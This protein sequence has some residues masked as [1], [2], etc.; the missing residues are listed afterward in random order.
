MAEMAAPSVVLTL[1]HPQRSL[2]LA[3]SCPNTRA[4]AA[5]ARPLQSN[6]DLSRCLT[7]IAPVGCVVLWGCLSDTSPLEERV[8]TSDSECSSGLC[9]DGYCSL[10]TGHSDWLVLR[11]GASEGNDQY[12]RCFLH[13]NFFQHIG[14]LTGIHDLA[15]KGARHRIVWQNSRYDRQPSEH[16][17]IV[18]H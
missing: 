3:V 12:R 14:Q 6:T 13:D 10:D 17:N 7:R 16:H 4:T 18:L 15:T 9:L 8:C 11:G 5:L 1:H 2:F